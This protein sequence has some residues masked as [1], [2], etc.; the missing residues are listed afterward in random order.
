MRD[1][2]TLFADLLRHKR[3]NT[4][5]TQLRWAA[6]LL[7]D[8]ELD[9]PAS[10]FFAAANTLQRN[11]RWFGALKGP[12]R[13]AFAAAWTERGGDPAS[14]QPQMDRLLRRMGEVD[15][16]DRGL[17]ANIAAFVLLLRGAPSVVTLTRMHE[18][19]AAWRADHPWLTGPDD[20]PLAALLASTGRS[21]P[22]TAR[23]TEELYLGL[24]RAG[25]WRG[26]SL[27]AAAQLLAL[28]GEPSEALV[29][30]TGAVVSALRGRKTR[31]GPGRYSAV[32]TLAL[33][34]ALPSQLAERVQAVST[35]LRGRRRPVGGPW[36]FELACAFVAD[37]YG[38]GADLP[39]LAAARI[40]MVSQQGAAAAA[41]AS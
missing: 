23:R 38:A 34:G 15:L 32:A 41:A 2:E 19:L 9:D 27:Q 3:W 40:A 18:L 26:N 17:A 20:Y 6:L 33:T 12:V 1:Y 10:A 16:R 5:L 30:R 11:A 31:V 13:Y 7:K 39:T 37:E 29:W 25:F 28:S 14:L 21:V 36:A 22:H 8:S 4:D 24:R 35:R